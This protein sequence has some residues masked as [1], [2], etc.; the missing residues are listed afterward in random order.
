MSSLEGE[1]QLRADGLSLLGPVVAIHQAKATGILSLTWDNKFKKQIV[2]RRGEPV[3][4]RS[5]DPEE[6]QASFF[7]KHKVLDRMSLKSHLEKKEKAKD[8][9]PLSDWL[10]KEGVVAV[11]MAPML[12][13]EFFRQRLFQGFQLLKGT[14]SFKEFSDSQPMEG[15]T[16]A[17]SE[18]LI[19]LLW[20]RFYPKV[21]DAVAHSRLAPY[22][23][24]FVKVTG[25]FPFPLKGQEQRLWNL[26][27][28]SE[29]MAKDLDPVSF[30]LLAIAHELG[31]IR[32]LE[33]PSHKDLSEVDVKAIWAELE[34][35]EV[36][37]RSAKAHEVLG[38]EVETSPEDCQRAF[39]ELVRK[40]HPDRLGMDPELKKLSEVVFMRANQAFS[41]LTDPAKRQEYLAEIELEKVGGVE[42]VHRRLE[43]ELMIPQAQHALKRKHYKSAFESFLKIEESVKDDGEIIADRTF[44]E[45]MMLM[46]SKTDLTTRFSR[47]KGELTKAIKLR[48]TYAAAYYYRGVLQK[49]EGNLDLALRD[50]EAALEI[51]PKLAEALSE[52]RVIKMRG[53]KK[54]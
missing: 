45:L 24:K 16:Q 3:M 10:V 8:V 25:A 4:V 20:E 53:Q 32:W 34:A 5:N 2:F 13:Q 51:D 9:G 15:E 48:P 47:L 23:T 41:T 22:V 31:I 21:T 1:W 44:A 35:L 30:K 54:T 26:L 49:I 36:K 33:Q 43:A 39:Y 27:S 28:S 52:I 37:T 6:S 50:F 29:L 40:Y 42:A 11:Q 14:A 7:V 19:R 12:M 38:V 18:P 17:L 46:E